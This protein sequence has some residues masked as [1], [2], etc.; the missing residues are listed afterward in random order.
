MRGEDRRLRFHHIEECCNLEVSQATNSSN[1]SALRCGLYR[2]GSSSERRLKTFLEKLGF[3]KY[4]AGT[5]T[6]ECDNQSTTRT[7][8]NPVHHQR[9]EHVNLKYLYV[10][11]ETK[12]GDL[13]VE[14]LPTQTMIKAVPKGK[15][16]FRHEVRFESTV[17]TV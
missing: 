15:T 7:V 14:Y 12:N 11:N 9:S 2:T 6:I 1:Q 17:G 4:V 8:Q 13:A 3:S 5:L 10:R 16:F